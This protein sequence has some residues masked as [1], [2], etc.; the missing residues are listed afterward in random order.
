MTHEEYQW[1]SANPLVLNNVRMTSEQQTKVFAMYNR[2][3]G[4]NKPVTS[5]GRCVMT[6]KKRLK[7]EYEKQRS[8]N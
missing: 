3:T 7:F 8:K 4:E 5:C 1:L 2:I 6:I